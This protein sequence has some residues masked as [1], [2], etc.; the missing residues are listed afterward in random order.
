MK[1][2]LKFESTPTDKAPDP[3]LGT[4]RIPVDRYTE[5]K[6]ISLEDERLWSKSWLLAGVESDVREPGSYF[7]FENLKESFLITRAVDGQLR[8]FYNVCQH[9]G[10][11]LKGIG[12]GHANQI[13]CGFHKWS[14]NLDGSLRYVPEAG[15]F[16]QG[17]PQ[18]ELGLPSVRCDTWG[19]LFGSQWIQT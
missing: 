5:Q 16:P 17:T 14:W 2:D 13:T 4:K 10:N 7:V 3:E 19:D 12:C 8:A 18:S 11:R 15:D 1:T 6:Y 9:R